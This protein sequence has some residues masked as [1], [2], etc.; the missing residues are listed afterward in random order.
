MEYVLGPK[1]GP[2]IFCDLGTAPPTSYRE[3]LVLVVQPH[4]FVCLNKYPFAAGHVLV[5]PK[6]HVSDLSA[7]TAEEYD[8]TMRLVRDAVACLGKV[9]QAQGYN[10]GFNLGKSAGA[11][12]EEHLHAHVV[13]RWNGDS[14]FMPVLAEVRVIPEHIDA[15]W[16]R[17][18]PAFAGLPGEHPR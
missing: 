16:E 9:T 11:G 15:T 8:A 5:L 17:L 18:V 4:A 6:R 7:L 13:P 2:C 10:I 12:I 14:N 3:K 1:G